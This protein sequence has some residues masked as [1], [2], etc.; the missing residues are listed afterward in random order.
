MRCA[1]SQPGWFNGECGRPAAWIGAHESG[2]R[3]YFCHL[4]KDDG[5]EA[6]SVVEWLPLVAQHEGGAA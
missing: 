3:Q 5:Y 2:H 1:N 4:C 6:A